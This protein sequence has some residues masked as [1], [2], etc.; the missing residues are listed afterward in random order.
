MPKKTTILIIVLLLF[1]AGLIYIAVKTE[2]QNPEQIEEETI[3]EEE[4][5]D[6]VPTINPQTQISFSPAVIDTSTSSQNPQT[7][8]IT[9]NTNGQTISGIQLELSYDPAV[10]TNVEI[11]PAEN[12]LFGPNPSVL[13]NSVD[14]ALGRISFAITLPSLDSE[15]V[16]GNSNIAT[17]TFT[18]LQNRVQNTQIVVLPKTTVRSLKSTNSLLQNSMP[19]NINFSTTSAQPVIISPTLP[20]S[21]TQSL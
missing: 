1:T 6:L 11:E 16:S 2:Q 3:S 13:I 17:I 4:L 12:N 21:N 20:S 18:P 14:P 9:A 19:L 8:S 7:V 10:L 5:T 15:E